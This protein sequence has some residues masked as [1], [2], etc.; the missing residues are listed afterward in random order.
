MLAGLLALV[1]ATVFFGGA[2]YLNFAEQPAHLHLNDPWLLAEWKPSYKGR[3][4][5]RRG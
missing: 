3:F 2:F 1:E 5:G 4:S